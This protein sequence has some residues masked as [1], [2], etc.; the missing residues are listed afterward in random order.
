MTI[1]LDCEDGPRVHIKGVES[2]HEIWSILK[3][4]YESSD[5]ADSIQ[6]QEIEKEIIGKA[7]GV[8]QWVVLVVAK[9]LRLS[10]R[11]FG[12]KTVQKKLRKTPAELNSL[13]QDILDNIKR[14][15]V[16]LNH[17]S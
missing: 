13:H 12:I 9:L 4:Q 1:R 17:Y 15:T 16:C 11:G 2:P 7:S 10:E 6:A 8:F 14:R 3:N 5:L